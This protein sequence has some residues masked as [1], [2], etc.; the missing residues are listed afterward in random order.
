MF[1]R[2]PRPVTAFLAASSPLG[3]ILGG[4]AFAASLTPSL[5]PRDAVLQGVLCGL[6][7]ATGYAI[8]LGFRGI[9]RFLG[10]PLPSGRVAS[11]P[12]LVAGVASALI[13]IWALSRASAWQNSIRDVMAMDPVESARPLTILMVAIPVAMLLILLGRLFRILLGFLSRQLG[14]FL[15]HRISII[16]GLFMVSWL[17]WA[18]GD[19]ILLTRILQAMDQTYRRLDALIATDSLPPADPLKSGS[20]ASLASWESLGRMGRDAVTMG[21]DPAAIAAA[22]QRPAMTPLR[23]YV[24]LNSAQSIPE[25]AEMALA[26]LKRIGA[27]KRKALVIA[28][29]TGTGWIDPAGLAPAEFLFDGDIASVSVQ[30]SYLPSW[31]SLLV[32]PEYGAETAREVFTEVYGFWRELP[33][34]TRPKL[35]LFGLSLG[36]L[37]SDLSVEMFDVVG[38]PFDAAVW[39]GPPFASRTWPRVTRER[40]AGTPSWLPEFGN[41]SVVR[42]GSQNGF[43]PSSGPGWGPMRLVYLQYASDPI[44]FFET[45]SLVGPPSWMA[46]PRGPDVS[47]EFQWYPG[48]TFLQLILDIIT[49][50][51]TKVGHGHVYAGTDYLDAWITATDA[52]GWDDAGLDRIRSWFA[53]QGL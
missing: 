4:L 16:A 14:R 24:G 6:A 10:L 45:D 37:N 51:T 25:R 20:A 3:L 42:F 5:I 48:V 53:E 33:R 47:P 26:E 29:P 52:P 31:L 2:F 32:A 46:K 11:I 28:T 22:S 35:Y 1:K 41:G 19:G 8:G 40:V 17:F 21:P 15:P 18:I 30:Y 9:W 49:A 43:A 12:L 38:D 13:V 39:V 27:F 36:S 50:T 23:V 44:V 7:F 34:A